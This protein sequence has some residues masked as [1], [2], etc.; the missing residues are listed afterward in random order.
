MGT[1]LCESCGTRLLIIVE[2]PSSRFEVNYAT[3]YEE[4]LLERISLLEN[5]L[6]R[7]TERFEKILDVMM[8]QAQTAYLDHTLLE[9][10]IALLDG[11]GLVTSK[12]VS[13][14]WQM[15][16]TMD[17]VRQQRNE[18]RE[19][20]K[21]R[22]NALHTD[23][24]TAA[25]FASHIQKGLE[26]IDEGH[27]SRGVKKLEKAV[28]LSPANGPLLFFLGQHYYFA[29]KSALA[30]DYLAQSLLHD[31][32]NGL[33]CLILG[34][35]CGDSGEM[36]HAKT[37]FQIADKLFGENFPGNYGL[38]RLY[39]AEGNLTEALAAFKKAVSAKKGSVEARYALGSVYYAL[40]RYKLAYKHL[41]KAV[42]DDE[43]YADAWHLLGL[44]AW[45]LGENQEALECF[46]S[47]NEAEAENETYRK[48]AQLQLEQGE[49]PLEPPLFGKP[50]RG[51]KL[52]SG[53]DKRLAQFLHREV[54]HLCM[55][56]PLSPNELD[57]PAYGA[58]E[59]S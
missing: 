40:K 21:E 7:L 14:V 30:R 20:L 50:R 54:A 49:E 38:G 4:H 45:R 22:F 43:N 2:P 3:P 37:L 17:T 57:N 52:I 31:Q 18:R 5:Y 36:A 11:S 24:S 10:L 9:S 8:R 19:R 32:Q 51:R 25:A 53:G 39:V 46:Q 48:A 59:A 33:A 28:L 44:T 29:N 34:L 12:E 16:R 26:L 41:H 42:E 13:A 6:G 27:P 23:E 56:Y 47:A 58:R 15:R 55:L 35:L 1:E